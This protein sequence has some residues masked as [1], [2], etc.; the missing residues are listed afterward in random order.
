M[1]VLI[2]SSNKKNGQLAQKRPQ[3][4][5]DDDKRPHR[6]RM[7]LRFMVVLYDIVKRPQCVVSNLQQPKLTLETCLTLRRN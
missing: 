1:R 4:V 6:S 7:L 5:V 2:L 3:R